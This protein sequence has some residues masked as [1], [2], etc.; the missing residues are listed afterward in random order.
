MTTSWTQTLF[1]PV[2]ILGR[3]LLAILPNLL[4][5][6]I[7]L[8]V[9]LTLAW[10]TGHTLE[11]FLRAVGVDRACDRLGLTASLLRG[12]IK[13]DPSHVIGRAVHWF[14]VMFAAMASLEALHIESVR[15]LT[16][17]MLAYLPHLLVAGIIGIAGYLLS[18][19]VGQAVLIA[20][21]NAGLP[22]ARLIATG[23][24]WAV[25]LV[26]AAM[27][28]EQLG[29]AQHIVA[30]GFGITLG[31]VVLAAALAFGLGGKDLAR[32]FLEHRFAP[33][34]RTTATDDVHHH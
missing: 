9:G 12:G 17:A 25:Q 11:R 3:E 16:H 22:P 5:T 13:S 2:A 28:L 29:I 19:F 14:I 23:A 15:H 34:L 30:L 26:A 1:E 27:A 21:V 24:R 7:L 31:G 18:N 20:A 32:S 10:A 8:V 4:A 6:A 33:P